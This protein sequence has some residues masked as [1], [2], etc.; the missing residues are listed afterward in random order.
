VTDSFN[1]E[2]A[3]EAP[4]PIVEPIEPAKPKNIMILQ[5][6]KAEDVGKRGP[7][8]PQTKINPTNVRPDQVYPAGSPQSASALK[9]SQAAEDEAERL[10]LRKIERKKRETADLTRTIVE[11]YNDQIISAIVS[12]GF[13]A[14][15][16]YKPGFIPKSAQVN[17]GYTDLANALCINPMQAQWMARGWVEA[18]EVPMIKKLMGENKSDGPGYIWMLLGGLGVFSYT[19]QLMKAMKMM[20]ELKDTLNQMKANSAA[21]QQQEEQQQGP[22]APTF[23]ES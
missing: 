4:P 8:R 10:R 1:S 11:E 14:E 21:A 15:F 9:A 13:P 3:G 20:S 17:S 6:V 2:I 18:K 22:S 19:T 16:L 7:G 23:S 5:A 12:V